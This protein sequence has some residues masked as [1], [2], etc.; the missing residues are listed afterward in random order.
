MTPSDGVPTV[1]L[2]NL[3]PAMALAVALAS[4][5]DR[6]LVVGVWDIHHTGA[7]GDAGAG[8]SEGRAYGA[9][10]PIAGCRD[11][12]TM[13]DMD[14]FFQG[15]CGAGA[16]C[17]QRSALF[18]D[19]VSPHVFNR[20][21]DSP[22]IVCAQAGATVKWADSSSWQKSMLWLMAASASP[23]C[24][25]GAPAGTVMAAAPAAQLDASEL[26]CLEGF[27]KVISGGK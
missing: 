23:R 2:R 20:V 21:V 16:A 26:A 18:G 14:R 24:P 19:L 13:G 6:D 4:C 12:R 17:H 27:L 3:G 25:D 5:G 15:R 22:A 11:Y 1:K 10:T 9:Q 7:P 8:A